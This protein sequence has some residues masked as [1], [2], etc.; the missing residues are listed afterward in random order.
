MMLLAFYEHRIV[1][2]NGISEG[3]MRSLKLV[4]TRSGIMYGLCKGHKDINDNFPPFRH[5]LILSAI[6]SSTYKLAK[7]L[8]PILKSLASNEY[9]VMDS[10]AF[11]EKIIEQDS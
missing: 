9:T 2:S 10:F 6:N 8:V 4:G 1:T 7:F 5:I 3:T 11:A